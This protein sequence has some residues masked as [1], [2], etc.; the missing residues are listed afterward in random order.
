MANGH[1]AFADGLPTETLETLIGSS[2]EFMGVY[3]LNIARS[4]GL[5]RLRAEPSS[6]WQGGHCLG[7]YH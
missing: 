5:S 6:V 4:S 7:V 2:H 1:I 3:K